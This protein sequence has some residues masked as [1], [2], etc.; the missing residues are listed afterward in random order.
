[1]EAWDDM[2]I[3]WWLEHHSIVHILALM[4]HCQSPTNIAAATLA[5]PGPTCHKQR[6]AI[7]GLVAAERR[8]ELAKHHQHS[9]PST[10]DSALENTCKPARVEGMKG[11][12]I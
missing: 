11:I 7:A 1:M 10:V 8:L 3:S 4:V 9:K 12:A 2:P 5:K 6:A